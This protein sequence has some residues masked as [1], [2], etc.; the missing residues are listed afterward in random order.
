M[1]RTLLPILVAIGITALAGCAPTATSLRSDDAWAD[2][3]LQIPDSTESTLRVAVVDGGMLEHPVLDGRVFERWE[4]EPVADTPRNAHATE[5]A[6]L[7]LGANRAGDTSLTA[8][9]ELL[10]VRVLNEDGLGRPADVAAGVRWALERDAEVILMSL[11]ISTDD[12]DLRTAIEEAHASEV[13]VVASTANGL[14]EVPSYPAEYPGVIGVTSM[15]SERTL[16][17]LAGVRGA[18]IAAPGQNVWAPSSNQ[19]FQLAAGTSVAAATAT[20][21]LVACPGMLDLTEP[22]I[23]AYAKNSD[24]TVTSDQ[25]S[26]PVLRCIPKEK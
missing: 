19:G 5:M 25:R 22:E 13:V 4:A 26:I 24:V 20:S 15:D 21:V 18:D 1:R 14:A 11:S 10:D 7:L 9:I 12:H 3:W 16:A 23:V 6:G 17:P 8:G 2:R